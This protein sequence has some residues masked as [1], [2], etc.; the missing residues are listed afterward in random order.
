MLLLAP[1]STATSRHQL[2]GTEDPLS[3][4]VIIAKDLS[5][6]VREEIYKLNTNWDCAVSEGME[7]S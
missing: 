7:E 2:L 4:H 5:V 6:K 3:L 1:L